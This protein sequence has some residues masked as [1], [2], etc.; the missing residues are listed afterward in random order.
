MNPDDKNAGRFYCNFKVHK[1]HNHKETP[2]VR[3]IISQ[4]GTIC[5]N[6]ATYVD[7]HINHIGST[8][9]SFLQDTP[10]FLRT[11]QQIN[12]GQP[13]GKNT[14]LTTLDVTS[15]Y[16]NIIHDEGLKALKDELQKS[17]NP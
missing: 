8:H 13:L 6:I 4:S 1:P 9:E 5:E 12:R 11:I 2:P 15:L 16:T 17:P 10:D 7:H 3:P 14:V